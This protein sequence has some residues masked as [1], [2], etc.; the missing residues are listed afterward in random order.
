MKGEKHIAFMDCAEYVRKLDVLE[1][2]KVYYGRLLRNKLHERYYYISKIR[3]DVQWTKLLLEPA[4][5][6]PSIYYD[7]SFIKGQF[8]LLAT[9]SYYFLYNIQI[10]N[11]I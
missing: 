8:H 5:Q 7:P 10:I 6:Y 2:N 11:V 1:N 4:L 9:T 3:S